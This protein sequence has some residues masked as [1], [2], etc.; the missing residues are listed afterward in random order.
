MCILCENPE[1]ALILG[2]ENG[3]GGVL[4]EKFP[5]ANVF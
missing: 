3:V 1:G 4:Q 5:T 2:G